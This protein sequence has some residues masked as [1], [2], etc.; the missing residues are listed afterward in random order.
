MRISGVNTGSATKKSDRKNDPHHDD[1]PVV[2]KTLGALI[3]VCS[4]RYICRSSQQVG[5]QVYCGVVRGS[6]R[7]ESMYDAHVC[8]K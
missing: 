6:R 4:P 5:G 3:A 8:S 2:M 7:P 1:V